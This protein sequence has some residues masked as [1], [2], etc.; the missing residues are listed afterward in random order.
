MTR[1]KAIAGTA[2]TASLAVVAL[3]ACSSD[4]SPGGSDNGEVTSLTLWD[5]FTQY[6]TGSTPWEELINACESSTEIT[7]ER[8]VN[9]AHSDQFTQ[10][11]ASGTLP[12]VVIHDNPNVSQYAVT[13]VL[14]DNETSGV[15]TTEMAPNIMAS[16]VVD[17]KTYGASIGANSLA[18]Y[19]NEDLFD[20]AGVTPPTNWAELKSAAEALTDPAER[21]FGLGFSARP[22]QEGTFQFLPFFWGAG[23]E[24]SDI[25]SPKAV[26]ALE[27]WTD[28]V[29][30]GT[31]SSEVVTLNQQ[32]VR[33][34]FASGQ[35]AMMVNGTWQLNNLDEAGIDYG[36][37]PIPAKDGGEAASPLGGEFALA[38]DSGDD[39]RITAAGKFINC[40]TS[41]ENLGDWL[42]GQT[43]ISP[44]ADQAEEQA[45][46]D[47]RLVPWV[48]AVSAARARTEDLGPDYQ[49]VA[50]R[51][52]EALSSSVAD[53]TEPD[54][55]LSDAQAAAEE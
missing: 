21:Q 6:N 52:G 5:G 49:S 37:V 44:Y 7:I 31:V 3:G 2:L 43:Y 40:M 24:L 19:Y 20:A 30:D 16:G 50:A 17:G 11:A 4:G 42:E 38:V 41:R 1:F 27:F 54:K 33:D 39:A 28:M 10:A 48:A 35:F 53:I 34:R 14:A 45:A 32:E 13:G 22:D 12:D 25:A 23:A 51:L 9:T 36:V 18:L 8:T 55:A 46:S 29:A 26:E 47:E 15:D